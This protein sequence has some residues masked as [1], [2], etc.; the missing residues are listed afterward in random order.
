MLRQSQSK[1][2]SQMVPQI[3]QFNQLDRRPSVSV[4]V[5]NYNSEKWLPKCFESLKVQTICDQIEVILAD[6]ASNDSS[7]TVAREWLKSLPDATLIHNGGNLGFC[8]GNNI[9]ARFARG[10]YILFLNPD[11]WLEPDCVEKLLA[12]TRRTGAAAV[13]P[14]VQN[15]ADNSHQDYGFCGFDIFGLPVGAPP[16]RGPQEVFVASGC[17]LFISQAAFLAVDGFDREFFMY[18]D[19]VDLSW[20]I[21]ISGKKIVG[22]PEARVH[23]RGAAAV[24]PAGGTRTVEF[25]TSDM[26]RFMTN[27]NSLMT[28]LKNGQHLLL[29][30]V[31]L[32]LMLLLAETLVTCVLVRRLSF[33]EA[34]FWKALQD[35]WRLR[36][37]IRRERNLIAGI[38]KRGDFWMLR[39]WRVRLNR[40]FEIK[41]LFQFGNPQVEAR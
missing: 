3:E 25:R 31:P 17:C 18:S 38:R 32:Q 29:L 7:L 9:P 20:R 23:H 22:V 40:W 13:T 30:L 5:L 36:H 27:R 37:H 39:F 24:N 41:R 28:L 8:E 1:S 6:N 15:Y 4:I 19:E 26:K 12:E 21:W 2:Q 14:W 33:F 11:A 34:T 35:C 10:E 16:P